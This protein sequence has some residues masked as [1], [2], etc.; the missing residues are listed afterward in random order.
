MPTVDARLWLDRLNR[1]FLSAG[2]PILS[3]LASVIRNKWLA[4]HLDVGGIGVLAQVVSGFTWLGLLSGLGMALPLSRSVAESSS[5]GD[6]VATRRSVWTA[7]SM[8]AIVAFGAIVVC[9][10]TAEAVSHALL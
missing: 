1:L 5:R 7:L 10:L 2:T 3:G 8:V 4:V 6:D 9:V